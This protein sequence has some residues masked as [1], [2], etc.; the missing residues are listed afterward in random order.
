MAARCPTFGHGHL[1]GYGAHTA[2][3]RGNAVEAV[4]GRLDQ[5]IEQDRATRVGGRDRKEIDAG[6][7]LSVRE[8]MTTRV[9]G[10]YTVLVGKHGAPRSFTVHTEGRF[11]LSRRRARS[12]R[13]SHLGGPVRVRFPR[14]WVAVYTRQEMLDTHGS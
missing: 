9:R 2:A 5:R 12:V 4:S 6:A 11:L 13:A 1:E 7:D 8:D 3:V 10:S 14:I